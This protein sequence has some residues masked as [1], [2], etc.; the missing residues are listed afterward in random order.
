MTRRF[1]WFTGGLTATVGF[2]VGMVVTGSLSPSP[3]T[4]APAVSAARSVLDDRPMLPPGIPGVVNFADVAERLNPAVVNIDAASRRRARAPQKNSRT[5][6][7][8]H[9]RRPIRQ[10]PLS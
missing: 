7:A 5:P 3:A 6:A 8:R 9:V 2:L 1:A 4:S 10:P